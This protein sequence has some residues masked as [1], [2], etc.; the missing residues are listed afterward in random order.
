MQTNSVELQITQDSISQLQKRTECL[1]QGNWI[2]EDEFVEK[3]NNLVMRVQALSGQPCYDH[4]QAM[5]V[6]QPPQEQIQCHALSVSPSILQKAQG[7]LPAA[8]QSQQGGQAPPI[9]RRQTPLE[10]PSSSH[11]PVTQHQLPAVGQT[12]QADN[13]VHG[14]ASIV[15]PTMLPSFQTMPPAVKQ[16]ALEPYA[17][18]QGHDTLNAC[19]PGQP[20]DALLQ[21]MGNLPPQ[22]LGNTDLSLV[23]QGINYFD[24]KPGDAKDAHIYLEEIN[25]NLALNNFDNVDANT[26][27]KL[28]YLTANQEV[29]GFVRRQ[30]DK[31]R[32]N[33]PVLCE[34]IIDEFADYRALEGLSSAARVCQ[35]RGED[36]D[37]FYSRLRIAYFGNRNLPGMEKNVYF[38][39]LFLQNLH[40]SIK[41]H[42]GIGIDLNSLCATELRN[43]ARE[44]SKRECN[45]PQTQSAFCV[46]D[47]TQIDKWQP[48]QYDH[49]RSS[50]DSS[51]DPPSRSVP[52]RACK[53]PE[54]VKDLPLESRRQR[55]ARR[56]DERRK[57]GPAR[58]NWR[59]TMSPSSYYA[60]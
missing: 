3:V 48:R 8:S 49:S 46:P 55:K 14:H 2:S 52:S 50:R 26:K 5:G 4:Y 27:V 57:S 40:P 11:Y 13:H 16:P 18:N 35:N 45:E 12:A 10:P 22:P 9:L 47:D 17:H 24:P 34:A 1:E 33:W 31:V 43:L 6:T 42:L 15:L 25:H 54:F 39:E 36:V 29:T 30:S 23:V 7:N 51:C 37:R 32:A 19:G 21:S 38:K 28:I 53:S 20:Q 44:A 41:R 56:Y 58:E 60:S 59:D